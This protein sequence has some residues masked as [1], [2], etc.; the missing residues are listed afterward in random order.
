MEEREL[1]PALFD[2][3]GFEATIAIHQA[4]VGSIQPDEMARSLAVMLP[5][6]NLDDRAEMLGGMRA[7]APA[8]V[9]QGVWSLA[10]SVLRP[11]DRDALAARLALS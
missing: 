4:I 9:F 8:E 6:M 3:I 7:G 2:A 10:G 5:A 11:A 1:M